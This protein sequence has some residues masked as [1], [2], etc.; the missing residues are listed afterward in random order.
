MPRIVLVNPPLHETDTFDLAPPLGLMALAQVA[1]DMGIDA[2][3]ID[4]SLPEHSSQWVDPVAFYDYAAQLVLADDP[5]AIAL[6]SMGLNTHVALLIGRAVR[7]RASTLPIIAGGIHLSSIAIEASKRFPWINSFVTGEGESAFRE[8]LR[9]VFDS[10]RSDSRGSTDLPRLLRG[11][12]VA[13][14]R[15]PF[16]AY[17]T[18]PL[19]KYFGANPRHLGDYEGG[20]GC[21]FKC[22]FCY[23]PSHYDGVRTIDPALLVQEWA[24]IAR[25]GFRHLFA[26]QDN[27]TND[28]KRAL[29]TCRAIQAANLP[30]TWNGYATLPQLSDELV[31]ALARS[32]CTDIYLGVDAVTSVQQLTMNKRFFRGNDALI[33]RL[34]QMN[35]AGVRPTCA[36][37]LDMFRADPVEIENTLRVA[38]ECAEIPVPIRINVLTPYPGSGLA[39][40]AGDGWRYSESKARISLDCPEVVCRNELARESPGL[41]PFHA[42]PLAEADWIRALAFVRLAQRA[43]SAFP[44]DFRDLAGQF[45][46]AMLDSILEMSDLREDTVRSMIPELP[47][48]GD[49]STETF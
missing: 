8:W 29:I 49:R 15:H 21:V 1:M 23:S 10:S 34:R 48:L 5:D 35:D 14:I 38:V 40:I 39:G 4:F 17:S 12:S 13:D 3:I 43:V 33:Q 24:E 6:T 16:R 37:I 28:P 7:Q 31:E 47:M 41:F 25:L 22:A 2:H 19:D 30:L 32:K 44:Q 9:L 46:G 18:I 20:R 36:F 45:Q 11:Q 42:T 27:F 26:V